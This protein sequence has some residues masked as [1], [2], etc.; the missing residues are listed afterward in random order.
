[1]GNYTQFSVQRNTHTHTHT[2]TG[3]VLERC[4]P[5]GVKIGPIIC[6]STC[7]RAHTHTH[8]DQV[9]R[10]RAASGSTRRDPTEIPARHAFL[11]HLSGPR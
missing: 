1:M 7:A 4:L 6:H 9:Q 5:L 10:V 3:H 8:L 2:H 11:R